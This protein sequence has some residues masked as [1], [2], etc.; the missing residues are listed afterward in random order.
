MP[1]GEGVGHQ[2]GDG[3]DVDLQRVDAQVGLAGE[4]CQ[5]EG[6]AFQ[7][8]LVARTAEVVDLLRGEELQRMLLIVHRAAADRQALFGAVLVD[9]AL[10]DQFTQQVAEIEGAV[11]GGRSD[12]GHGTPFGHGSWL[13]SSIC[14][15]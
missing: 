5:P 4:L 11:G 12:G 10:G 3:G 1:L 15:S 6:E 7:V 13:H 2:R 14:R 9:P 8:E